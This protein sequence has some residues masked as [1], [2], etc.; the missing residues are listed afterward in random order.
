MGAV[1]EE[2]R[3]GGER[4]VLISAIPRLVKLL[5]FGLYFR[6]EGGK[7]ALASCGREEGE[8]LR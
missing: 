2:T 1:C 6:H 3:G 8:A 4:W 5:D 7:R